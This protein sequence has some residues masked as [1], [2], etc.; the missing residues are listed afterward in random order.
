MI[1]I[2]WYGQACF[3]VKGKA[4]SLVFDPYSAQFTGLPQLRLDADVVCVSHEHQDHNFTEAV[5]G[6]E[7]KGPFIIEGPGEYEISKVNIVG[8]DSFHDD[9]SG[10]ERGSNTIYLAT[11]DDV[12][13]VHLGD[14]G[15][16][17]LAQDQVEQLS[18]CDV[19]MIPVGGVYTI[20]AKDAP[21]II[22]AL[23]PKI[24][25]PMHYKLE[26][27][28]FNLDT[29]DKF[30]HAMGKEKPEAQAKLSVARDR[31][32]DEPQIVLLSKQ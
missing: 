20:G 23:E 1:D 19:L 10:S 17:K 27:L 2:T 30:L 31:L 9:Q 14:L 12:N 4:A 5:G 16:S 3:K 22:A 13:I 32:P 7:D 28:K 11:V 25:I 29:V 18:S 24:I 26:G 8:I 21:D 6:V 15:Q